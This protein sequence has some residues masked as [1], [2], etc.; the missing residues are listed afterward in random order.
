MV[1]V[2]GGF[3]IIAALCGGLMYAIFTYALKYENPTEGLLF[4]LLTSGLT[5]ILAGIFVKLVT[6]LTDITFIDK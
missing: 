1:V 6:Q 2:L 5:V 3:L 4:W